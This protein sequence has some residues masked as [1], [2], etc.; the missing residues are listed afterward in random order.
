MRLFR[1]LAL[2]VLGAMSH[3]CAQDVLLAGHVQRVILEPPITEECPPPCPLPLVRPDGSTT[4]CITN[5][6]GCE[7]M[8]VKIDQVFLGDASGATRTFTSR[9]SEWGPGF[10]VTSKQIIISEKAGSVWWSYATVRDGKTYIDPKRLRMIGDISASVVA[11][12]DDGLVAL[13][14]LLERVR[15]VE[16]RRLRKAIGKE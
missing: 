9:I 14:A 15:Q 1:P 16:A 11:P 5:M 2:I 12:D 4:V 10:P 13:D 8:E 6:G 3:A 7:S